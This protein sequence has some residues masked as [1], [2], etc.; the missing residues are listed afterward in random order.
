MFRPCP[1]TPF[2]H[3]FGINLRGV[4]SSDICPFVV[5]NIF[6]MRF[7]GRL[8]PLHQDAFLGLQAPM[9]SFIS[10]HS[11]LLY[12]R[13]G[14]RGGGRGGVQGIV[15]RGALRAGCRRQDACRPKRFC[16]AAD[17]GRGGPQSRGEIIARRPF[18]LNSPPPA[19]GGAFTAGFHFFLSF[20]MI[21]PYNK[22]QNGKKE[23][24]RH[25]Q[26]EDPGRGRRPK[27]L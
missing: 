14:R 27:Y 2:L 25:A 19:G 1:T 22:A 5:K 20:F 26:R 9:P 12:R 18:F 11:S 24:P 4:A 10:C 8:C 6:P 13:A 3:D 16:T 17:A 15:M 21:S 7:Y 23:A